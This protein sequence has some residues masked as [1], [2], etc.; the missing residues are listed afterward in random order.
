MQ[1]SSGKLQ[2]QQREKINQQEVAEEMLAP[3]R[4][5]LS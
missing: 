4:C 2:G 3:V 5:H 1:W